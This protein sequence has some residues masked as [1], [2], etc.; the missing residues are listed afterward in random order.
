MNVVA[1]E[2][3]RPDLTGD[4][5]RNDEDGMRAAPDAVLDEA[6]S[7]SIVDFQRQDEQLRRRV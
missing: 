2:F 3:L 4:M 6:L 5:P 7:E 1:S